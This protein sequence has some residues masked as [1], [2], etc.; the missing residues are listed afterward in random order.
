MIKI[1]C[2]T[3]AIVSNMADQG[4]KILQNFDLCNL[5][6]EFD[7]FRSQALVYRK[8]NRFQEATLV[9]RKTFI[10]VRIFSAPCMVILREDPARD[11]YRQ[12]GLSTTNQLRNNIREVRKVAKIRNRYNQVPHMPQD[13]SWESDKNT[14]KHH[15]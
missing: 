11:Y 9:L 1:V 3:L 14:T 4:R 13:T 12:L 5:S 7:T 2:I 8:I 15:K 10:N 6:I